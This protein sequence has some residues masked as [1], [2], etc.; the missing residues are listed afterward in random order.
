M[1]DPGISVVQ[2]AL[3]FERIVITKE[4][5]PASTSSMRSSSWPRVRVLA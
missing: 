4:R 2:S 1:I 5:S 3:C